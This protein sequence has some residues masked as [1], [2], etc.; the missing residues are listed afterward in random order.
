MREHPRIG[1][2]I[3][4]AIDAFA[5]LLP[6]VKQHHECFDGSGYPDGLAGEEIVLPARILAVADVFDALGSDRPYRAGLNPEQV[7]QIILKGSG[8]KFDPQVVGTLLKVKGK[9]QAF[10]AEASEHRAHLPEQAPRRNSIEHQK[11]GI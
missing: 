3:L 6:I 11:S 9:T 8:S 2:R 1:E 10:H 5:E 7:L 4:E